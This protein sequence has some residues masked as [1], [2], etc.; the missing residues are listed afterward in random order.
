MSS[1]EWITG[2]LT[3]MAATSTVPTRGRRTPRPTGEDR[4]RA[5]LTTAEQLLAERGFDGFSIDDLA[6][7][8]G[9]SRPT[10]YFY[11]ASK[12][13][14]VLT[15]LD[16]VIAEAEAAT[17]AVD[18]AADRDG[19]W[20]AVI[21][22]VVDVFAAHRAVTAAAV[23]AHGTSP[24]IRELWSAAMQRWV[25]RCTEL[26]KAERR[27]GAAP[28]GVRA[29]DLAVALNLMNERVL[30]AAFTGEQPAVSR[31]SVA[32]V[33]LAVWLPAIYGATPR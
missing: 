27:R 14:V 4:E 16:R 3:G 7:G 5:I 30:V 19:S 18:F 21:G 1:A 8:A 31:A 2:T 17:P 20:R 26:I 25:D 15:L 33:L 12:D 28:K 24:E 6:R 23:R 11:F 10:F 13:A 32:D 29:R 22:A 9:L